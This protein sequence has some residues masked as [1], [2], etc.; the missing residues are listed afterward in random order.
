MFRRENT[1]ACLIGATCLLSACPGSYAQPGNIENASIFSG[2]KT[3][4]TIITTTNVVDKQH[5]M[6]G[7]YGQH[8]EPILEK[9]HA[10]PD[11]RQKISA[12][13]AS[14]K[15]KIQPLREEYREK[16][17][18]FVKFLITGQPA[19]TVMARQGEL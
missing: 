17:Q 18:Q 8:L 13:V 16:S 9:I 19:E 11:Q 1:L 12:V 10:N 4:T 6:S 14:Y 5:S 2:T 3:T 7:P 15:G